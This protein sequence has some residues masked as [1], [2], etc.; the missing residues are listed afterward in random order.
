MLGST[1]RHVALVDIRLSVG[2][3]VELALGSLQ[4]LEV[5]CKVSLQCKL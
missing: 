5:P 2:F 3:G 1:L 4:H